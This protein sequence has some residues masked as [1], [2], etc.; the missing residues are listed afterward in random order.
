V[1]YARAAKPSE[2]LKV[3]GG[4]VGMPMPGAEEVGNLVAGESVGNVLDL[5]Q[6]IE[7]AMTLKG[8]E[9]HGVISAAVRSLDDA[10]AAFAKYKLVPVAGQPGALRVDGLG[11]AGGG[12]KA[13]EKGDQDDDD[14]DAHVC[15]LVPA[16]GS[17]TR[18]M[19]GDSEGSLLELAPWLARTTPRTT[20][21][22]DLHVEVHL[23]PVRPLIGQMRRALPMLASAG[24]G[25][26]RSQA[27][28]LDA[29]LTAAIDDFADFTSDADE[30]ALDA[31]L[32]EPQG[33][34]AVSAQFR[35]TTSVMAR[36]AV[37]HPERAAAPPGSYWKLPAD[38]D[39]AT[40]HREIDASDYDHL[41]DHLADALGG[42]LGKE[43]M[44]DADRKAVH[45]V[46]AHTLDLFAL[47]SVYASGIDADAASKAVLALH[48]VKEGDE[49]G[50][51]AAQ[52]T[53]AQKMAGWFV[54]GV[55]SP[56]AKLSALEKEWQTAWARPGVAK[57][58]HGKAID[59][60]APTLRL[61]AVPK[62]L[63]AKDASHLELSVYP[64]RPAEAPNANGK[65]AT[66]KGP[67]KPITLHAIVVPD[68]NSSW[69]VFAADV[70][71]A[72]AKAKEVLA[73]SPGLSGRAGLAS[74]KDA[75]ISSGGFFSPRGFAEGN[76]F[77]WT[78][79]PNSWRELRRDPLAVL[80]SAPDHGTTPILFQLL[81][82]PAAAA[83][84]AGSFSGNVTV[85]K[86]AIEAIV[87]AA[88][89]H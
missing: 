43:G 63:P 72:V 39:F 52:L 49:A 68:G 24:L 54:V 1:V 58:I 80:A 28:E 25:I 34:I 45:D 16:V 33:S 67:T 18:L 69:L 77:L 22:S 53:A 75:K 84:P 10:K 37:E 23:A 31:M 85:P 51:E 48:A 32:G 17:I 36:L 50:R 87:R 11:N 70:D 15:E 12:A 40:F 66:K 21:P 76:V 29:L 6:P 27:P 26:R 44:A 83:S 81:A 13:G 79:F 42:A 38:S 30:L 35:S 64:P 71:L 65:K 55:D 86:A 78:L 82:Q 59:V 62:G 47:P 74:M 57:W 3:I 60:P 7:F 9:Q 2:G 73:G 88:M 20:F 14:N 61:T 41:R 5:D 56:A 46:A 4:W 89:H 19:C 8:R